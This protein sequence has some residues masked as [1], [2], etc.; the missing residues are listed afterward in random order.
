L[1]RIYNPHET[2][3]NWPDLL[4]F[5]FF[6]ADSTSNLHFGWPSFFWPWKR[7]WRRRVGCCITN[8]LLAERKH[9]SKI[10]L[11]VRFPSECLST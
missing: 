6:F 11:L 7:L 5:L 1:I 4:L 2:S 9:P 8:K 10:R 3:V